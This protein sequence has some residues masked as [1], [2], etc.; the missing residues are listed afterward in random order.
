MSSPSA[1]VKCLRSKGRSN[2]EKEV[3]G[4]KELKKLMKI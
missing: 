1:S 4:V 3:K 2:E